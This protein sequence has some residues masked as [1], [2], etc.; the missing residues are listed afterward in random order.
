[1]LVKSQLFFCGLCFWYLEPSF[2]LVSFLG[3]SGPNRVNSKFKPE[4][5]TG[6]RVTY[7]SY[8]EYG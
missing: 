6:L 8:S 5:G 1:M 7:F 3:V 4:L 2:P